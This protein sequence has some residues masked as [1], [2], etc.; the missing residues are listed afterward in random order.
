MKQKNIFKKIGGT[1]MLPLAVF[2]VMYI[3][4]MVNGKTYYGTW[5]MWRIVLCDLGVAAS[6]ALGIGLQFKNGRF[7]FSGGAIMLLSS[8]LAGHIVQD[9][10]DSNVFVFGLL[11]ILFCVVFSVIV[12]SEEQHV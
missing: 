11:C 6:C 8:I 7:D 2:I 3:L 10:F 5:A 12:R 9:H 1:I 4:C